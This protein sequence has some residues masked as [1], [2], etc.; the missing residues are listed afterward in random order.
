MI[1]IKS[2]GN[3]EISTDD[4]YKKL[5][6]ECYD[7]AEG[8]KH[9]STHTGALLVKGKK[10]ILKGRNDFPLGVE[11][12][13]ERVTG[14][15]KHLYPNHAERDLIYRAARQGVKTEG[16]TMVMPWL[17]CIA[18][19]NAVISSGIEKLV[20]HKQMIDRTKESW[21]EELINAVQI[22]KEAGIKIIAYDGVVGAEAYMHRKKWV[23]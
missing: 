20:V 3:I 6:K 12:T 4:I 15:N 19:A 22:M 8:S 14:D 9:P 2:L 11:Y 17:P 23:A 18:C 7:H 1:D 21:Q 10:V 16:L 5:L 13:E